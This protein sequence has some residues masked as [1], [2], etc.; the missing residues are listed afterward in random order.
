MRGKRENRNRKAIIMSNSVSQKQSSIVIEEI[1]KNNQYQSTRKT[2][3]KIQELVNV[4]AITTQVNDLDLPI[5]GQRSS[6]R[7][8]KLDSAI[9]CL[10]ETYIT[11]SHIQMEKNQRK[12]TIHHINRN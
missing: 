2:T 3:S 8:T 12:K 4:S 1:V 6:K 11:N 9:C 10:Q 5:K 7:I